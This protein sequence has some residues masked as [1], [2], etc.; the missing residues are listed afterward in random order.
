[1]KSISLLFLSLITTLVV[2]AQSDISANASAALQ[3]GD[4]VALAACFLPSV[5]LSLNGTA[6]T[7]SKADAQALL[8]SFFKTNPVAGYNSKHQGSSKL[9]DQFR[10]GELTTT[11]G[12]FRVTFYIKKQDGATGIRQIKIEKSN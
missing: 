2:S 11:N 1:M 3:K 4:A 9:D 7:V 10:V 8:T 5:E 12:A 6:T